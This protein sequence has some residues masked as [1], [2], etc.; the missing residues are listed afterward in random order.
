MLKYAD[1]SLATFLGRRMHTKRENTVTD[2]GVHIILDSVIQTSFLEHIFI[3]KLSFSL[4]CEIEMTRNAFTDQVSNR[5][6]V[7]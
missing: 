6:G 4:S 3:L 1:S 7:W 2:F 5:I